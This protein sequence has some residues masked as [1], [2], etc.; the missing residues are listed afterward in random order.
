MTRCDDGLCDDEDDA[1]GCRSAS[2]AFV[3]HA[4]AAAGVIV[5]CGTTTALDAAGYSPTQLARNNRHDIVHAFLLNPI[6][7]GKPKTR[8]T[9]RGKPTKTKS[10]K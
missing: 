8:N 6:K 9:N 3:R 1:T 2:T 4:A 7:A 10:S 5:A